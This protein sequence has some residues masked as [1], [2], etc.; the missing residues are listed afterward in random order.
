M[1]A[2]A[3]E[4]LEVVH[5]LLTHSNEKIF[6]WDCCFCSSKDLGEQSVR[7]PKTKH[8]NKEDLQWTL[9]QA[10]V[11]PIM[12]WFF[13]LTS[14]KNQLHFYLQGEGLKNNKYLIPCLDISLWQNSLFLNMTAEM[15]SISRDSLLF[16]EKKKRKLDF[17]NKQRHSSLNQIPWKYV[18]GVLGIHHI[19]MAPREFSYT[20]QLW[21]V[22]IKKKLGHPKEEYWVILSYNLNPKTT[23][24]NSSLCGNISHFHYVTPQI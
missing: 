11:T 21:P 1:Q 5:V 9:D 14:L 7:T 2:V 16:Q 20:A 22:Q 15:N 17:G 24:N 4:L 13:T 12:S 10:N 23:Q 19:L 18:P 8:P 3:L 6:E